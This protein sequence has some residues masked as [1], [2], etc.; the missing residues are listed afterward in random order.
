MGKITTAYKIMVREHER[1]RP[2]GKPN[3]RCEDHT[4]WELEGIGLI[5]FMMWWWALV[6]MVVNL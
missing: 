2:L 5:R 4:K 1:K 6:N 3:I